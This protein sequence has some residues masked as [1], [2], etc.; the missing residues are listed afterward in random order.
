MASWTAKEFVYGGDHWL[1][2]INSSNDP[3][4]FEV[5][6]WP[7]GARAENAFDALSVAL[8]A[9]LRLNLPAYGVM[10]FCFSARQ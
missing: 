6:G 4:T 9:P 7:K 3:A 2:L 1:F 5:A 8:L 10:A